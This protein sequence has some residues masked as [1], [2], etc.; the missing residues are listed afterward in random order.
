MKRKILEAASWSPKSARRGPVELVGHARDP[1]CC[2]FAERVN[3]LYPASS[4]R[5]AT[6]P[7]CS[8]L[9]ALA[10][11]PDYLGRLKYPE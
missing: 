6:D 10:A 11:T 5:R 7:A 2:L 9:P 4:T 3:A 8:K 1:L